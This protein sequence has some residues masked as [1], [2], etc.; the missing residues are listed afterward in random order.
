MFI[1]NVSDIPDSYNSN[2]PNTDLLHKILL[3]PGTSPGI[4]NYLIEI[5]CKLS[6]Q[7]AAAIVKLIENYHIDIIK[8]FIEGLLF[9]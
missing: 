9:G 4:I 8:N 3:K 1:F 7:N 6:G 5:L 2:G